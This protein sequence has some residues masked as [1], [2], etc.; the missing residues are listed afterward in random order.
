MRAR[1]SETAWQSPWFLLI[2]NALWWNMARRAGRR[3]EV[4]LAELMRVRA[5]LDRFG[6]VVIEIAGRRPIRVLVREGLSGFTDDVKRAAPQ[7]EGS[8]VLRA[9]PGSAYHRHK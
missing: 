7:F 5:G 4:P 6:R 8:V 2:L 1:R 3:G 9:V